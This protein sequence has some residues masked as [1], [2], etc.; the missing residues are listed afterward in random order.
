MMLPNVPAELSE[1]PN[2]NGWVTLPT[3]LV[4]DDRPECSQPDVPVGRVSN[5]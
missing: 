5:A 4:S 3:V 1:K 2:F